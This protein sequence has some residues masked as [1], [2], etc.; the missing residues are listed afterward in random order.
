MTD[1]E[2]DNGSE[3]LQYTMYNVQYT[4]NNIQYNGNSRGETQ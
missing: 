1:V 3:I 4:I 2:D